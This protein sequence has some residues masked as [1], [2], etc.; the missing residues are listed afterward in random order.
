MVEQVRIEFLR[1]GLRFWCGQ[2]DGS[3]APV[4]VPNGS[5]CKVQTL[6]IQ[7]TATAFSHAV[8]GEQP[9][10]GLESL[11]LM[12]VTACAADVCDQPIPRRFKGKRPFRVQAGIGTPSQSGITTG[13]VKSAALGQ[14]LNSR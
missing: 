11:A 4:P 6:R 9:R 13:H 7:M 1:V 2:L 12:P 10:A 5:G 8:P 3:R 14:P